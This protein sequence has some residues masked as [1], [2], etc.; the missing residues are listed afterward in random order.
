MF[1][2][3]L[4]LSTTLNTLAVTLAVSTSELGTEPRTVPGTTYAWPVDDADCDK[5]FKAHD[6]KAVISLCKAT[7]G[8]Y[9]A[10]F[11]T[12][13]NDP[14]VPEKAIRN[15]RFNEAYTESV[16]L[17]SALEYTGDHVDALAYAGDALRL[18]RNIG[19][20]DV[21]DLDTNASELADAILTKYPELVKN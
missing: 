14:D 10:F 11:D 16:E 15:M 5:A 18:A 9:E 2:L 4:V 21:D 17:A 6:A 19:P 8:E 12:V 3:P 13:K 7:I 1:F 20:S